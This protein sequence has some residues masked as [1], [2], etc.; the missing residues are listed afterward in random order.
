MYSVVFL[1]GNKKVFEKEFKTQNDAEDFVL[2]KVSDYPYE[3]QIYD[4]TNDLVVDEGEL[5]SDREIESGNLD[6]MFGDVESE[7]GFDTDDFFDNE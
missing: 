5:V 6:M 7:E 1:K 4:K 3:Y 2:E